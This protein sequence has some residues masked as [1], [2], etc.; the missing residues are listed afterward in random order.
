MRVN[1]SVLENY[2]SGLR[3]LPHVQFYFLLQYYEYNDR[4]LF[5][6]NIE[7]KKDNWGRILGGKSTMSLHPQIFANGRIIL[8]QRRQQKSAAPYSI[9]GLNRPLTKELCYFIGVIIG[10]GCT[11]AYNRRFQTVV[12]GDKNLDYHYYIHILKPL[13]YQLFGVEGRIF[14]NDDRMYLAIH[15]RYVFEL[16]TQRFKIPAGVKCYTVKIPAEIREGPRDFLYHTLRGMFDT[17][18]GVGFDKREVY[19]IPYVRVNYTSVSKALITQVSEIL[20][21]LAIPHS[22]NG[23]PD[24]SAKQIQI[25]GVAN[26]RRF[27]DEIGFSNPRH[28]TKL[29]AAGII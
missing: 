4:E 3:L 7:I 1:K 8:K 19:R 5:L 27:V 13:C 2:R 9:Y 28:T 20:G 14:R 11:N 21:E 22:V 12:T 16:L 10:D 6:S 23:R 17:D 25:N 29:A 18:G 24:S 15:S 26:V